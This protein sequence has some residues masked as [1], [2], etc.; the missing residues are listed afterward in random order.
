MAMITARTCC[1]SITRSINTECDTEMRHK[2]TPIIIDVEASGFGN[3]S[4]PIEVGVALDDDT[5]FCSLIHPAPE[6]DHWDD[7]A[8][9]V[10]RIA[11]DNGDVR[12][13]EI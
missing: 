5:K 1:V 2:K 10:H 6:W 9:K 3:G 8:E 4:Y 11:R 12:L 7:E 13:F